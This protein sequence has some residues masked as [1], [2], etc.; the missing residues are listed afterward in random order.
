M[1]KSTKEREKSERV[2]KSGK[3]KRDREREREK[4]LHPLPPKQNKKNS[5]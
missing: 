2:V 4:P 1:K 3:T 5:S